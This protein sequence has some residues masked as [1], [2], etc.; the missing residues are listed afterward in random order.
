MSHIQGQVTQKC[1]PQQ[2]LSPLAWHLPS[3]PY[4]NQ[5]HL[6]CSHKKKLLATTLGTNIKIYTRKISLQLHLLH[7]RA[8]KQQHTIYTYLA[9]RT[10]FLAAQTICCIFVIFY[11]TDTSF[12]FFYIN[13]HIH[14]HTTEYRRKN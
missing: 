5:H 10:T 13:T 1:L 4:L 7:F 12:M 11:L 2:N 6:I 9:G 3:L 8:P 14:P